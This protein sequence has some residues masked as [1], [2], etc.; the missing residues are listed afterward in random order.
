MAASFTRSASAQGRPDEIVDVFTEAA[1]ANPAIAALRAAVVA[2]Y[3]AMGRLDE[4]KAIF[5]PDVANG[6]ADIPRNSVWTTAMTHFADSAVNLGHRRAGQM[7]YDELRPF[8]D[9]LVSPP[10]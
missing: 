7:L 9:L 6:F 2:M 5:E 10:R 4:A 1:A 3:S 8:V